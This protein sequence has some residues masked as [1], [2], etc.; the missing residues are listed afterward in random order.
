MGWHQMAQP[1]LC[2]G[3]FFDPRAQRP[4]QRSRW[5]EDWHDSQRTYAAVIRCGR[6]DDQGSVNTLRSRRCVVP[7]SP[8][9]NTSVHLPRLQAMRIAFATCSAKP[10]GSTD[11]HPTGKLLNADFLPWDDDTVDWDTYD[12]VVLRS[13]RD[14]IWRVEEFLAWC[15]AIGPRKLRNPP[16]LVAFNA[17]KRHY[18]TELSVPSVPTTFV[19][20]GDRP[21]LLVGEVV[22]KPNVSAGARDTGRFGPG[23]HATARALIQCIQAS[24]RVALVQPYLSSVEARGETALV[25]LGGKLS[26]VLTKR[27]ILREEGVAPVTDDEL[28]VARA[29][30]EDNLVVAGVATEAQ[31]KLARQVHT[32]ISTRFGLPVY[33]RVDLVADPDGAPVLLELE[34]IEPS[35][36]L[37]TSPGASMRLAAA[38][39]AS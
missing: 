18:L 29:M 27:A 37:A 7:V 9:I 5:P 17:D 21:P 31:R 15:R 22:V 3:A 16:E 34:V 4:A 2:D 14:Y 13:V 35:L 1:R 39:R 36:Y 30:L 12:R 25:F 28:R 20:P 19:A 24:G 6:L 33:A 8:Q 11:D 38:I 10:G 32:E 23:A 26:H